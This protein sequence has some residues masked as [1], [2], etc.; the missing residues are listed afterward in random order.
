MNCTPAAPADALAATVTTPETA[1]FGAGWV[2]DTVGVPALG[3]GAAATRTTLTLEKPMLLLSVHSR[4][5]CGPG[6][7]S[8]SGTGSERLRQEAFVEA[9]AGIGDGALCACPLIEYWK[10]AGTAL[11]LWV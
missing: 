2:M 11:G 7:S 1:A 5:L 4:R 6:T 3:T 9:S 10:T 8:C